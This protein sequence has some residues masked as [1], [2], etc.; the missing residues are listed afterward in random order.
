MN[1]PHE[2]TIPGICSPTVVARPLATSVASAVRYFKTVCKEFVKSVSPR[3]NAIIGEM[4]F[5]LMAVTIALK[6]PPKMTPIAR[7]IAF[8]L[9]IKAINSLK[10]DCLFSFLSF[11]LFMTIPLFLF[12][13]N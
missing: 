8:P 13:V 10:I 5:L 7:A 9:F 12:I 4:I 3:H 11:L 6:A 1:A 2:I